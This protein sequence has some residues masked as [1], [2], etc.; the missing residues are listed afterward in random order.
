[1]LSPH[2]SLSKRLDHTVFDGKK[3]SVLTERV[4]TLAAP[5]IALGT[6]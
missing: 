1:M 5:L 4:F 6:A 3:W 2:L